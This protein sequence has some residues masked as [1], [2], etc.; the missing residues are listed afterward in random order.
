MKKLAIISEFNPFHN[1]HKYLLEKSKEITR[2]DLAIS[3]MSGDFVQRGQAALIDKFA[4][5][6]VAIKEGFDLVIEMPNFISLQSA[7]FFAYKSIEILDKVDI[8]YLCF[9]IENI[10]PNEFN[11]I[12][13]VLFDNESSLDKL[14]AKYLKE[15]NSYTRSSYL[16][17]EDILQDTSFISAN[18]IL[19]LEYISAIKKLSSKIKPIP[20]E[21]IGANNQ[22]K[23]IKDKKF[24]SSTAIRKNI[25]RD[26][27][28][29]L[30]KSSYLEIEAF[31]K[32][33]K[34]FPNRDILY[35]ILKYKILIERK[36]PK[37]I[38]CYEE[39]LE[40]LFYKNILQA[41]NFQDF[42]NLSISPRY[43]KS[44]IKRFALN[45]IL[46]NKKNLNEIDINFIKVL[47]F[48]KK[49][50]DFFKECKMDI[51]I[52]KKDTYKLDANNKRILE[53]MIQASNL[54]S[55]LSGRE[56]YLDYKRNFSI[57]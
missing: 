44:R 10:S 34:S 49:A 28:S 1:G 3:F 48:N 4:R 40:N 19:A 36:N 22:D 8:D 33:Y 16:A 45:Y 57:K 30:P 18:N 37:E 53:N 46:E 56:L 35:E 52:N 29:F 27:A 6:N 17:M 42:L 32:T 13:E 38:L 21:R 5:A 23:A 43:T 7:S 24:A 9:G 31:K 51:V 20:V 26:L 15:G 39:G 25:D 14:T 2:S 54:Y 55:I 41:K 12:I 11:N 47:A 50:T